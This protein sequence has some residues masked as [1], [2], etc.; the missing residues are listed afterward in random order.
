MKHQKKAQRNLFER[1]K[2]A[3]DNRISFQPHV[4]RQ[5]E[6]QVPNIGGTNYANSTNMAAIL[7]TGVKDK[8]VK[9][10]KGQQKT[11]PQFAKKIK[12]KGFNFPHI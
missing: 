2:D 12:W 11:E 8:K 6:E 1:K 10:I 3:I 7:Y 4:N 5:G 9:E